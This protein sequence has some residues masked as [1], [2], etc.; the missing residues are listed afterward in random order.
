MAEAVA[1]GL[2]MPNPEESPLIHL[3]VPGTRHW[4]PRHKAAVVAAVREEALS[5]TEACD[6]YMLTEEEFHS[7]ADA[8]DVH[9]IAGLRT[10]MRTERRKAA[11]QTISEPGVAMLYGA[12]VVP[13]SITDI[14]DRGARIEFEAPRA[15]PSTFELRC[16]KSRRSWWVD[17]IWSRAEVAGVRFNNPLPAPW[18]I[19]SGLGAWLLGVRSTV[20]IDRL[21][22]R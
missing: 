22:A 17:V 21:D 15:L 12:N 4:T 20:S 1:A 13:C 10:N 5:F 3:P 7:W 16:Q 14:S 19:K 18:M 2:L 9:G 8:L 11:R 6:R